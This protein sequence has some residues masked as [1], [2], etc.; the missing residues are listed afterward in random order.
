MGGLEQDL[1][2][3][4][5]L[6]RCE[7]T[8]IDLGSG[9]GRDARYMARLGHTVI[10]VDAAVPL[11]RICVGALDATDRVIPLNADM[12]NLPFK[13]QSVDAIWACGSLLHTE[14]PEI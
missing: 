2:R 8:V 13:D 1:E 7:S 11:L 6:L 14:R 4:S 9:S 3:L 5:S 12:R 10:A